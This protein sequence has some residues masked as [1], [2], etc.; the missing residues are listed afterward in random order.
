M[1]ERLGRLSPRTSLLCN[2]MLA[3]AA[4]ALGH[5]ATARQ[6]ASL[7]QADRLID[8]TAT[9]LNHELDDLFQQLNIG[10][11]SL[12][13]SLQLSPAELRMLTY[14]PTH[15][16]LQE[17]GDALHVSRNTAKTHAVSIYRK[18]GVATRSEAVEMARL[19]GILTEPHVPTEA[20][21]AH[22][23]VSDAQA[24]P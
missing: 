11:D 22:D 6:W 18:L 8:S 16:S 14:L 19:M 17:I 15:L 13:Y 20:S 12:D 2:L 21:T 24:C 3:Q 5:R 4:L 7:A 10:Q 1:L 9:Q 23:H